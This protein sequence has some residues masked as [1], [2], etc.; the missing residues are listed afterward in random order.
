MKKICC[1]LLTITLLLTLSSCYFAL[2]SNPDY[3]IDRAEPTPDET[4]NAEV[5][6]M[7]IYDFSD[8]LALFKANTGYGYMDAAGKIVI[9]PQYKYAE[10][11]NTLAKVQKNNETNYQYINKNGETIYSFTGTEVAVGNFSNE[12]FWVET[13][14]KTVSGNVH[15]MTYYDQNGNKAFSIENATPTIKKYALNNLING[16]YESK[17][18]SSFNKWG[19]ALVTIGE[20]EKFIDTKGNI[21]SPGDFGLTDLKENYNVSRMVGNYV[22][23]DGVLLFFD[24]E[25]SSAKKIGSAASSMNVHDLMY[26]QLNN[27]Y[28]AVYNTTYYRSSEGNKILNHKIFRYILKNNDIVLDLHS[29][30]EFGDAYILDVEQIDVNGKAHF[31]VFLKSKNDVYFSALIDIDGNIVIAPNNDTILAER[32]CYSAVALSVYMDYSCYNYSSGL[33]PA[34]NVETGK[35]GYVD[36][37]GTF[38]ISPTYNSAT[39]FQIIDSVAVAVVNENTIINNKGEIIFSVR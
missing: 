15:T 21:I 1:T 37:N 5:K 26:K 14:N 12:Y 27:D 20:Y 24:F 6:I 11:F 32:S 34:Q 4:N 13:M 23:I 33:F 7:N 36:I 25:N 38:L 16:V 10:K 30:A 28:Y 29:I 17:D 9:E 19:Y 22:S 31:N 8:G 2:P 39:E 18:L 35:M 3:D